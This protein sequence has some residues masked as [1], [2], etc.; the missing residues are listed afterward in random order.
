MQA[1]NTGH[2]DPWQANSSQQRH[3][4]ERHLCPGMR[5]QGTCSGACMFPTQNKLVWTLQ[6][7]IM[8]AIAVVSSEHLP[9]SA[10]EHD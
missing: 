5:P 1:D 4:H 7:L 9:A 2:S 8:H 6:Q 10:S 3:L